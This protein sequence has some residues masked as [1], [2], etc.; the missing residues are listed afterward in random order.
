MVQ[1]FVP[2][3]KIDIPEGKE[4]IITIS[5]ELKEKNLSDAFEETAGSWKDTIDCD[6]LI[7][8]TY[9]DRSI[10]TRKKPSL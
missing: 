9:S 6:K 7:K 5:D 8:N 10:S 3:E 2:L 1:G 4:F